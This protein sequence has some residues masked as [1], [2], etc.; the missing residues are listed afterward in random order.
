MHVV[1]AYMVRGPGWW[2]RDPA[3]GSIPMKTRDAV[4]RCLWILLLGY[5]PG[6]RTRELGMAMGFI[7]KFY[8]DFI[9]KATHA[10]ASIDELNNS[11]YLTA[12]ESFPEGVNAQPWSC[13]IGFSMTTKSWGYTVVDGLLPVLPDPRPWSELVLPKTSREM[14]MSLAQKIFTN[15]I[16]SIPLRCCYC[17]QRIG[18]IVSLVWTTRYWK[19]THS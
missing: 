7:M 11:G 8:L 6:S 16:L 4:Y 3:T 18:R 19:D 17:R 15:W 1:S 9:R 5:A 13:V 2:R 12:Y 10:T 14:L